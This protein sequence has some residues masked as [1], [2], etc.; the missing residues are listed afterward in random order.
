MKREYHYPEYVDVDRDYESL[1]SKQ[2][3]IV[4]EAVDAESD[5]TNEEIAKEAGT[6]IAYAAKTRKQ[7]KHIVDGRRGTLR[8]V[9]ADGEGSYTFTLGVT[10]TFQV[11]RILP[12]ELSRRIY[13]QV[14]G[15]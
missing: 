6:S 5:T 11:M 13:D 14:R 10:E 2:K 9:A 12:D 8:E 1:T 15:Q 7:F 3:A 4:N